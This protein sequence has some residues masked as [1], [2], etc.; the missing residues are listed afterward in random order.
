[1]IDYHHDMVRERPV[2]PLIRAHSLHAGPAILAG[3]GLVLALAGTWPIEG[4]GTGLPG[5]ILVVTLPPA[6]LVVVVLSLAAFAVGLVAF[7]IPQPRHKDPEDFALESSPRPLSPATLLAVFAAL[8]AG[9]AAVLWLLSRI[10]QRPPFGRAASLPF[11][12]SHAPQQGSA[13]ARTLLHVPAADWGLLLVVAIFAASALG[14]ALWLLAQHQWPLLRSRRRRRQTARLAEALREAAA[15]GM[16]DLLDDTDPRLAVIACYRRCEQAVS[17]RQHRRY[18]WQ[19]PREFLASALAALALPMDP[20]ATLLG[21]FERA[22]FGDGPIDGRDR[23]DALRALGTIR[24]ALTE[25]G[26]HGT[27]R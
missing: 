17:V 5:R 22:R 2:L 15:G 1:M 3:C 21:V 8:L 25:R 23:T 11:A 19:T 16:D 7:L 6:L 18:P 26:E 12:A 13:V 4:G 10:D 14:A 27:G 20:V 9:V 24:A